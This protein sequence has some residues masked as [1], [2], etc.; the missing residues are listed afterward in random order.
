MPKKTGFTLIE[1]L[2][3]ST[4]MIIL[5]AV[6][7][8]SFSNAGKSA[9]DAKRKSD[10]EMIR[11]ALVLYRSDSGSY[12]SGSSYTTLVAELIE[13]G[14]LSSPQPTDPKDGQ[15]C[16]DCD[17][18]TYGYGYSGTATTFTLETTLEKDGT[19][20]EVNNP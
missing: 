5:V 3:A 12:I 10:L 13:Q 19:L 6:G 15:E 17:T 1:L 20:Y 4:I 11:Q 7:M 2:V 16:E 14:Y 18:K 8:V 9:R